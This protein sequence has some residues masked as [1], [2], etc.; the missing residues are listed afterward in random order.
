VLTSK[1]EIGRGDRLL[2][3]VRPP[4]VPYVPHKPDFAV[5]GRIIS[6]YGGVDAAGGGSIVAINR[7]QADGIEIG[8]VLAL[9]R[10]RTVVE[11]DEYENNVV[12]AIPPQRIGLLFIFRTFERISYGLVVQAIGTVE[13][14]DFA[15][16]PQ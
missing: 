6:V 4:L 16:V 15:R 12:I 14:N 13:V 9:E 3:A 10:N 8:H 11:R 7:G 2:P 5:D 1:E